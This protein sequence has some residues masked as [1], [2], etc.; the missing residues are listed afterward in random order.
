MPLLRNV[1]AVF[2][3]VL[4]FAAYVI[5]NQAPYLQLECVAFSRNCPIAKSF[6]T[7]NG[8]TGTSVHLKPLMQ[9][10]RR[11][12]KMG[13]STGSQLSVFINNEER[14]NIFARDDRRYPEFDH[15]SLLTLWSTTQNFA[16]LSI[17]MAI[18]NG[19]IA[20]YHD[21]VA[22]Y[23]PDFPSQRLIISFAEYTK[24]FE[25]HCTKPI[26]PTQCNKAA[27]RRYTDEHNVGS[28]QE[29]FKPTIADIL[30]HE[31][32]YAV[33]L[34]NTPIVFQFTGY[35]EMKRMIESTPFLIHFQ[36]CAW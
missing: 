26:D 32:G 30:R 33:D 1:L 34:S 24:W 21:A 22:D 25:A 35:K 17:G 3:V 2:T 9:I 29:T 31:G 10:M 36:V 16:A 19:W 5:H 28:Y 20:S 23:W 11:W 15:N 7:I 13:Y 27:L 14:V 8:K 18:Q 12:V 4:A 6:G